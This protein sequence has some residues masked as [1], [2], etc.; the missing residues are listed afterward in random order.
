MEVQI[1]EFREQDHPRSEDGR[2]TTKGTSKQQQ[3]DKVRSVF[4]K[5]AKTT[6]L[7]V[8]DGAKFRAEIFADKD[9]EMT[10]E[11]IVNHPIVKRAQAQYNRDLGKIKKSI[12]VN[13]VNMEVFENETVLLDTPERWK[14]RKQVAEQQHQKGSVSGKNA[15]GQTLYDGAVEH[16]FRAEIVIGAPAGG[17]SS[18]IVD[19]VS[20][21]TKSRVLDSD[22]IKMA[23]PEFNNGRGA[24]IVH[25]ESADI[26][27]EQMVMKEYGKGGKYAGDNIVIPI[28]G[29]SPKS[30]EKYLR[31]LKEAGYQVNL[32]F[33]D[34]SAVNSAKR[35]TTR[36]IETGR[37]LSP[38][39]IAS[40]GN[41]P[42]LTY[43]ELKRRNEFDSYTRY[44]NNVPFK[45][46]AKR[47]ERVGKDGK[48]L[49]WEDWQ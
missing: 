41:K 49:N 12:K 46:P 24:G 34:V 25:K 21:N 30:A 14:L 36:Y 38:E 20:R 15:N 29:K 26:I 2:F 37:F 6:E 8:P 44:D 1:A 47:I 10:I 45:T 4:T 9:G 22:E 43:E 18:V 11:Q 16:G 3:A 32:S 19:K 33:N 23:L 42:Q 7:G 31:L 27:L 28:V 48:P 40:I 17:K 5:E 39:Y 35:A 13:G